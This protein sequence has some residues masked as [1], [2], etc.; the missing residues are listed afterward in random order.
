MS[1]RTIQPLKFGDE[2]IYVEVSEVEQKG[3][4][5]Q[6]ENRQEN[7]NAAETLNKVIDAGT[8]VHNTIKGLCSTLQEAVK[9][10]Q[11]DEWSLEINLGIKGTAG[12]PFV[13]QGEANGA[14]KIT[15][16]WKKS[17]SAQKSPS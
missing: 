6:K 2:I 7:V 5:P 16:T 17:D 3:D 13:T 4:L 1:N 15:A 12:I 8:Q 10:S 11:P 9:D 14:V